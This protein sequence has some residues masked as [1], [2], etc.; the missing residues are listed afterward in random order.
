MLCGC[1]NVV[2]LGCMSSPVPACLVASLS[3]CLPHQP[4]RFTHPAIRLPCALST[5]GRLTSASSWRTGGS[6]P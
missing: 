4:E 3:P 6:G 5:T 2:V 1:K